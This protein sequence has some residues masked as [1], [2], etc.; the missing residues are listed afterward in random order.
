MPN[1]TFRHYSDR[2]ELN[3]Q[4]LVMVHSRPLV[5][6]VHLEDH[7]AYGAGAFNSHVPQSWVTTET[8]T[9][10]PYAP[11]TSGASLAIGVTGATTNNSEEL[12]G[13]LVGWNP[14]TMGT[15]MPLVLEV[16]A[17]FVGATTATDGDFYIGLADAVTYASGLPFVVS[18]ASA[19][20]TTAPTEWVGFGYSSI[21]TSGTLYRASANYIGCV[22]CKTGTAAVVSSGVAKDSNFHT[23]CVAV[24][25]S[26]NATFSIDGANFKYVAAAITA[27]T[28]LTPYIAAVAKASHAL[29]AT[30]D[31]IAVLGDVV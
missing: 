20:T 1:A 11:G 3:S 16:R 24:D 28:A 7:F 27:N 23:Y 12:A 6:A 18:A 21:P 22:S 25:S 29:T 31:Y 10:T 2:I 15:V 30:I 19:F 9:A 26:G 5:R 8:G 13:K 17:K 4:D 14:S